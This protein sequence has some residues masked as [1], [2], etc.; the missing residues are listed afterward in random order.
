MPH[1]SRHFPARSRLGFAVSSLALA[2]AWGA[3]NILGAN[4]FNAPAVPILHDDMG[5]ET[6]VLR[7]LPAASSI[8]VIS[9]TIERDP[10]GKDGA[11]HI[12]LSAPPGVSAPLAY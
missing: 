8:R 7:L 11:E 1:V 12:I 10:A 5:G 6:P 3:T 2:I 9:Q 4:P